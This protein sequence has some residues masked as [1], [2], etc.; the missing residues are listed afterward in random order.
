MGIESILNEIE[1]QRRDEKVSVKLYRYSGLIQAIEYFS[2]VLTFE[3]VTDAAFDFVNELLMLE[4]CAVY[5]RVDDS[6]VLEKSKGYPDGFLPP[7]IEY[8]ENFQN[9]AMFHGTLLC[10]RGGME[11]YFKKEILES[12]DI[13]I[14]VPLIVAHRLYGFMFVSRKINGEFDGDDLII[15]EAL[16]KLF[17]NALENFMRY[18]EL[19]KV[20]NELDEKIFNLFAINQSSK[21]LLSEL[22][23]EGLF[24]L[25]V[26]VFSELTQ[27]ASTG[28]VLYDEKSEKY[29]LRGYKDIFGKGET[30]TLDLVPCPDT[31]IDPNRII[32]DLSSEADVRYFNDLFHEGFGSFDALKAR[33]IVL[34]LKECELLGFVSLGLPVTGTEYKNSIFE[35]IESLASATY[36]AVSNA[37]LFRR[38]VEQKAMMQN[39]LERLIS[40]N[41]LIRNINSSIDRNALI[42][43]TMKTLNISFG[44]ERALFCSYDRERNVF[45]SEMAIGIDTGRFEIRP[46]VYWKKV[47][48]GTTVYEVV[49]SR[50]QNYLNKTVQKRIGH[51]SG[52]LIVPIYLD[53]FELE[54][55]GVLM[56]FKYNGLP[57][58]DEENLLTAETVA[59][60]IA[61][62]LKNLTD[63]EV[64]RMTMLP[65]YA[66][67]FIKN[68]EAEIKD[69]SLLD[70]D[71]QVIRVTDEDADMLG[72]NT[73]AELIERVFS[74]VY[75]VT[76]RE[77]LIMTN[78]II[79]NPHQTIKSITGHDGLKVCSY[80]LGR[81]FSDSD[82]LIKLL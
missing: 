30:V 82:S 7:K 25:S 31:L 29:T 66:K 17:N 60:H 76:N 54:I 53:R 13:C 4:K 37:K 40:L 48:E 65:D 64:Q 34:L 81:E 12:L 51:V 11:K 27:S 33:Y 26:D 20:N 78:E 18:D 61:P 58:N 45:I 1:N 49:E 6:Y 79:K 19:R 32:I 3:Q 69:A 67:A 38:V 35:L 39:K 21:A 2:S 56:I 52:V 43:L 24:S 8:E 22:S 72:R 16:M 47:F 41:N 57:I 36:I 59:G 14:I 80:I 9:L 15:L 63:I 68:L 23:L 10:E 55:L 46:N 70:L 74:K 42:D 28:F 50:I 5:A 73:T 77:T 75:P 44:V 71:F 62:L